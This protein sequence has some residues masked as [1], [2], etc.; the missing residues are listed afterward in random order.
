MSSENLL[1]IGYHCCKSLREIISK[2]RKYKRPIWC[3][4][5]KE[6]TGNAILA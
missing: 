6:F 1:T 2:K 5:C 4:S 3:L